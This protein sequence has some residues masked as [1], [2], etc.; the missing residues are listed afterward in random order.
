[1]RMTLWLLAVTPTRRPALTS[2]R[3]AW[4]PAVASLL[5]VDEAM[6][7]VKALDVRSK[8]VNKVG[9]RSMHPWLPI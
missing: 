2:V 4:A 5:D 8:L 7:Q 6:F 1:L 3:I 9:S